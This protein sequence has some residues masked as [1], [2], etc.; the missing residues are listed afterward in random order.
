MKKKI[1]GLM[2][3]IAAFAACSPKE[4]PNLIKAVAVVPSEITMEEGDTKTLDVEVTP[5][6]ATYQMVT[7]STDNSKVAKVSKKGLLTAVAEGETT[8]YAEI[9]GIKGEC[10]V[11]VTKSTAK[12]ESISLDKETATIG[13]G[14]ILELIPAITPAE[15]A[16]RT[17]DWTSSDKEVATVTAEG[18]VKGIKPGTATITAAA[19]GKEA[20]CVVSVVDNSV[21]SIA[22]VGGTEDAKVVE[23]GSQE[24]LAVEFTPK[25]PDNKELEWTSS[26]TALATVESSGEGMAKVTFSS[27]KFG[28]VT[29]TAK[30]RSNAS[31]TAAQ[32]FFIK[33]SAPLYIKPEGTIYAGKKALY[34]FNSAAYA[35]AS[36]V[37]WATGDKEVE[38]EEVMLAVDNAGENTVTVTI[39][40]G[41]AV[42]NESFTVNAEEWYMNIALDGWGVNNTVPVFSPD[43]KKAYFVTQVKDRSIV[44]IDLENGRLGWVYTIPSS[45]TIANSGGHLAVNPKTGDIICPC[46]SRVYCITSTGDLKWKTDELP[47]TKDNN[48]NWRN[49]SLYSGCGACFSNDC[50]V[51][52]MCCTP[53]G[54][55]AFDMSD[56]HIIDKVASFAAEVGGVMQNPESNQCQ[57][58]VFGD[59]KIVMNTKGVGSGDSAVSFAI[60]YEFDGSRFN[61]LGRFI[62]DLAG[63]NH[64]TDMSSLA[65]TR[66]QKTAFISGYKVMTA[67]LENMKMLS[68]ETLGATK[69]HMAPSITEDGYIYQP[70]GEYNGSDAA[71][72]YYKADGTLPTSAAPAAYST[73]ISGVDAFKFSS[74]PCDRQGNG[75]FCFWDSSAKTITFFKSVKGDA[76]VALASTNGINAYQASFN[77]GDGYLVCLTG[78]NN[79]AGKLLV[80]CVDAE[81]AHS[82]SG[83]GGDPCS[84]KNANLVY[85]E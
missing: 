7:W 8:V 16:G 30:S 50:S 69:W 17:V 51:V 29:I 54:L 64:P 62:S 82:W 74:C 52:F 3:A 60:F 38:G 9:D 20:K 25:N 1:F 44:E 81:R 55:Y 56:G 15:A 77:F 73:S 39:N 42:M 36:S 11:T 21:S 33:G 78:S 48:G 68:S 18:I 6:T 63:S 76:P 80:R 66:D 19:G 41:S 5:S 31:A 85:A 59:N 24:S 61:E 23:A 58:G 34:S 84:T 72:I 32:S 43:G 35:G 28:A 2:A 46:S 47:N 22:F 27:T 37:K 70:V 26:D 13:V 12:V 57:M 79:S 4:D 49:P 83:L 75:Y 10:K 40:F 71:I 65:I 14:E 67:D 53:R 45:E